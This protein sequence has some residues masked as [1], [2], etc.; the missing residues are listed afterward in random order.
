M[1]NLY[2]LQHKLRHEKNSTEYLDN[3][4]FE[5]I[6]EQF[7]KFNENPKKEN[8]KMLMNLIYIQILKLFRLFKSNKI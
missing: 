6:E 3:I 2:S 5:N 4:S 1:I 7:L 8:K